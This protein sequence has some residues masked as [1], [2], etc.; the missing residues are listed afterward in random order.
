MIEKIGHYSMTNP[1]S[2]F[3][4]DAMTALE[5][6]GRTAA[7]CN[8]VV[9]KVNELDTKVERIR[10]VEMP[11]KVSDEVGAY[12]SG[13]KFDQKIDQYMR[14][15]NDRLDNLLGSVPEGGTSMDAE[16]ID[17]RTGGDGTA[18]ANI[19][20]AIRE[21]AARAEFNASAPF[22][23]NRYDAAQNTVGKYE[24]SDYNEPLDNETMFLSG[25]IPVK[26]DEHIAFYD[27]DGELFAVRFISFYNA[28]KTR[29]VE[30]AIR[31]DV[32][33]V[34]NIPANAAYMRISHYTSDMPAQ[35]LVIPYG[36][37]SKELITDGMQLN[38]DYIPAKYK[39]LRRSVAG[40][41]SENRIKTS[42]IV[43][44]YYA[45]STDGQLYANDAYMT[46]GF[47]EI[48][49]HE[50][51][52]VFNSSMNIVNMRMFA[53][54]TDKK[55][56]I[57]GNEYV[58]QLENPTD[59]SIYVRISLPASTNINEV[60]VESVDTKV[61]TAPDEV[62]PDV[63]TI[64]SEGV[65]LPKYLTSSLG[66]RGARTMAD[67]P[68]YL[69]SGVLTARLSGMVEGRF[70][71]EGLYFLIDAN[72]AI[73]V[74]ING[75]T[76]AG[77]IHPD[78]TVA[79]ANAHLSISVQGKRWHASITDPTFTGE[80]S[81]ELDNP[82]NLGQ[83]LNEVGATNITYNSAE[84][85]KPIW[86]VGDSY[87]A[88]DNP[89]RVYQRVVERV[90]NAGVAVFARSGADSPLM[91][92]EVYKAM[93]LATPKLLIWTVGM[94]DQ[95]REAYRNSCDI[96]IALCKR[97]GVELILNKI[98]SIPTMSKVDIN[99]YIEGTGQRYINSPAAVQDVYGNWYA[100]YLDT[101]GVHPTAAGAD[102]LA[103]Q[104]I[105][106]VPEVAGFDKPAAAGG[107]AAAVAEYD[108]EVEDV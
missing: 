72:N 68:H 95:T 75:Q 81:G 88:V 42:E 58:E 103:V 40:L 6:A 92:A 107:A 73:F 71:F 54:Y 55:E 64:E 2:I 108:G 89:N 27:G 83:P 22:I 47:I 106:D 15:L 96:M 28:N 69:S 61:F 90:G 79:F 37:Y 35:L 7:K 77:A 36:S 105:A 5:L 49:P 100:A 20:T 91:V 24:T 26:A 41:A 65:N 93:K 25:Y 44:G 19:G 29:I 43:R 66:S 16:V 84:L 80:L 39:E 14:G 10:D 51:I 53:L 1:A 60:M 97:E 86:L 76:A 59:V 62:K 8:E 98:P 52:A 30:T 32:Q 17:G 82:V 12:I 31:R 63:K 13:G 67:I 18:F 99:A 87:L 45:A 74:V 38:D 9:G 50:T 102:A 104:L 57:A 3:D 4:E 56:F 101:D 48:F 21:Q 70:G 46:T 11:A 85:R 34:S 94:N 78:Y 33:S 23:K